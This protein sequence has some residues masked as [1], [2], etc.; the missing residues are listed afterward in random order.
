MRIAVTGG[1]NFDDHALAFEVLGG[2]HALEPITEL[3]HGNATGLDSIADRWARE[4]DVEPQP[5]DAD[6]ERYRKR[7]RKNPAGPIRNGVMLRTFRPEILV[8]FPGGNGT[9]DCV[10]QA[11]RLRITVFDVAKMVLIPRL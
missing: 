1:R 10:A 2:L 8:A 4:H 6:W 9:A 5:F 7:G 3:A 11:R